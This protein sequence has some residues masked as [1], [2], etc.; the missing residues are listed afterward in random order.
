MAIT[1]IK[2]EIIELQTKAISEEELEISKNHFLGSLQ[3][4]MA[5]PFS[6]AEKIKNI[7]I[8]Q[9]P[10][11]YYQ[12]LF[13]GISSL[14]ANDLLHTAQKYFSTDDLSQVTVG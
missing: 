3:L 2:N 9:L 11:D 13:S 1:E 10:S 5:N 7:K 4:D 8:Y 6:V 12:T 14:E